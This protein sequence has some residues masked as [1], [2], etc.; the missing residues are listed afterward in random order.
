MN[1]SSPLGMFSFTNFDLVDAC[2]H[3]LD[4]SYHAHSFGAIGPL[5]FESI[6]VLTSHGHLCYH[7]L[8]L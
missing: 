6:M 5:Y 4:S 8:L 1:H 3:G 7:A 2:D